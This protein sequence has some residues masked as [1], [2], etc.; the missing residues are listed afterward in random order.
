MLVH[1]SIMVKVQAKCQLKS[2]IA[3]SYLLLAT[4]L[5][6]SFLLGPQP[7]VPNNTKAIQLLLG[8]IKAGI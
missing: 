2:L 1:A 8:N 7:R 3:D 6:N 5:A 4:K